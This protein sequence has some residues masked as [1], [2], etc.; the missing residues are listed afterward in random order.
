MR[1]ELWD[2]DS[3]WDLERNQEP[4]SRNN[5]PKRG[6]NISIRHMPRRPQI[7]S[8][9]LGRRG[10]HPQ[11]MDSEKGRSAEE[12]NHLSP[13]L[14]LNPEPL[15]QRNGQSNHQKPDPPLQKR[16]PTSLNQTVTSDAKEHSPCS[17]EIRH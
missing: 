8:S 6:E 1:D 13:S 17:S 16:H 15:G 11:N 3:E 5:K 4:Q 12:V 10:S 9:N 2:N 7:K 14:H